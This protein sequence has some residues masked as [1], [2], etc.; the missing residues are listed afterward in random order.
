MI[1]LKIY[2]TNT[3]SFPMLKQ[4]LKQGIIDY[5]ELY[6]VPGSDVPDLKGLP[7]IYHAPNFNHSFSITNHDDV[8]NRSIETIREHIK[9]LGNNPIIFHPGCIQDPEQDNVEQLISTIRELKFDI[10]LENVPKKGYNV[11]LNLLIHKPE[12]YEE[13]IR[14][15]GVKFCLDV[16][17]AVAAARTEA[18]D[19]IDFIKKFMAL[20]P[21]MYHVCDSN[22][23]EE[24]DSHLP[25]GEG[26]IP[27]G[28]IMKLIGDARMTLETPRKDYINLTDDIENIR[29]LKSL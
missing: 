6:I 19:P 27:L 21:Y 7:L 8:Y 9:V 13:V 16:G 4:L 2:S 14:E 26:N 15:T 17:H 1:A 28:D 11:D 23:N 29:K 12:E 20:K 18:A 25:I 24:H 22:I 10:I 3:E 5:I